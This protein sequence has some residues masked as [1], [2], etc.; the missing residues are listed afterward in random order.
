MR[1][2]IWTSPEGVVMQFNWVKGEYVLVGGK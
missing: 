1:D 2:I